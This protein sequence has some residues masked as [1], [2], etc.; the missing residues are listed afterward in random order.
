MPVLWLRTQP[1]GRDRNVKEKEGGRRRWGREGK[2]GRKGGW[3]GGEGREGGKEGRREGE[4]ER[5]R[6]HAEGGSRRMETLIVSLLSAMYGFT[7]FN[8]ERR[9]LTM[10]VE[11]PGLWLIIRTGF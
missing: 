4:G 1:K 10:S 11:E 7:M 8:M 9:G 6:Q 2:E 5:L 3:E